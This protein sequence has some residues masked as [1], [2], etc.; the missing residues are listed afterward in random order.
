MT[1]RFDAFGIFKGDLAFD[2]GWYEH[3]AFRFEQAFAI[4]NI[5]G[6][7]ESVLM[8]RVPR[9][10]QRLLQLKI[11][12]SDRIAPSA[13]NNADDARAAF[14][15]EKFGR[16]RAYIAQSLYDDAFAFPNRLPVPRF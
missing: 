12:F 4:C 7:P 6:G 3:V 16:V 15:F 13:F 10:K 8:N 2:G 9:G 14:F 11:P 5:V 1:A